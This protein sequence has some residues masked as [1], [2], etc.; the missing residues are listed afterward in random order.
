MSID[1]KNLSHIYSEGTPFESIAL[2]QVTA[3]IEKGTFIGLIGHTGSGKSTLI[4]HLNV[5]LKPT[6][7]TVFLDELDI[8]AKNVNPKTIRQKVGLVF[9]YPEHQ[10]F[11][12]TVAK[13]VAFG[14]TNLGLKKD[15]IEKRVQQAIELVGLD[16]DT[17]K[18]KS[19]F[20]LSGGQMRRVAIAGVLAME[21]EVLVLDEPTAGL[22]PKGRDDILR[23]IRSLHETNKITVVLVSH[24]MED[25]AKFVD[26]IMVMSKGKL[27]LYDTPENVFSQAEMLENIGLAVP[28]VTYLMRELKKTDPLVNQNA[29]TLEQAQ[30]EIVKMIRRKQ[31]A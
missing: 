5:L 24:S 22:D 9:Q 25:I 4:Q 23:V 30:E 20:E 6:G 31:D 12:E 14:P 26:K 8:N 16:Y 1:I 21:P 3:T 27:A 2:D 7:G 17:V 29:Y 15:E 10:L 19:P 18:D 28:Q 11:E 13:D